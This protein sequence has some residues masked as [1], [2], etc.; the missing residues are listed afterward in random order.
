MQTLGSSDNGYPCAVKPQVMRK[1]RYDCISFSRNC[2]SKEND[3]ILIPIILASLGTSK[4][5]VCVFCFKKKRNNKEKYL[6]AFMWNQQVSHKCGITENHQ[7]HCS[8][9][10]LS[11]LTP[12]PSATCR[13]TL[14]PLTVLFADSSSSVSTPS[15]GFWHLVYRC[16]NAA[17]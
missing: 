13:Q 5:E 14:T 2:R 17:I 11:G 10:S 12:P 3:L 16:N 15:F 6:N 7:K 9:L 8:F 4:F 1:W